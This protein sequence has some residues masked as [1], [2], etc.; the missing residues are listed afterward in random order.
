MNVLQFHPVGESFKV[1]FFDFTYG[2]RIRG[3]LALDVG[4]GPQLA[5][6]GS[7]LFGSSETWTWVGH[8]SVTLNKS[9]NAFSLTAMRYT[10]NGGGVLAGTIADH[11]QFNWSRQLSR[12]WSGSLGP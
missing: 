11:F 8:G 5:V 10:T 1:H 9:R 2:H 7:P 6:F 12:K 4:G 3:K